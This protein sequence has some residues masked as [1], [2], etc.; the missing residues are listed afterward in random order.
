MPHRS[1]WDTVQAI[2][3]SQDLWVV[4]YLKNAAE[5]CLTFMD[6]PH[7]VQQRTK[8]DRVIVS[9]LLNEYG[10]RILVIQRCFKLTTLTRL[11][12]MVEIAKTNLETLYTECTQMFDE[13]FQNLTIK[14]SH[15]LQRAVHAVVHEEVAS[16]PSTEMIKI[17]KAKSDV[18]RE[19]LRLLVPLIKEVKQ[20]VQREMVRMVNAKLDLMK[21]EL[22]RFLL[23]NPNR[24]NVFGEIDSAVDWIATASV[25]DHND[26][27]TLIL[28]D[29]F[30]Q[31]EEAIYP[32]KSDKH[33]DKRAKK[34]PSQ[35]V[36]NMSRLASVINEVLVGKMEYDVDRLISE[37][38]KNVTEVTRSF[39]AVLM[40]TQSGVIKIFKE[41][42]IPKAI[43]KG[44][45]EELKRQINE[46]YTIALGVVTELTENEFPTR[47]MHFCR[48]NKIYFVRPS[49]D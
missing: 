40:S 39:E 46:A 35:L 31:V 38:Q 4:E 28:M 2:A 37:C 27:L 13:K 41:Q 17:E 24:E 19:A 33:H 7:L 22:K 9:E 8:S 25:S 45:K 6:T 47:F 30:T 1:D 29:T 21:S 10:K 12:R 23:A 26:K 42:F 34:E 18:V 16:R 36:E 32:M 20:R 44:T 11:E 43:T 3:S 48:T 5:V 49:L 15:I 14:L